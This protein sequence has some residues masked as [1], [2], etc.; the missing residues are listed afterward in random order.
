MSILPAHMFC[1][2]SFILDVQVRCQ[3]M[4]LNIIDMN[5]TVQVGQQEIRVYK[6]KLLNTIPYSSIIISYAIFGLY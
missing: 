1:D 2:V 5:V 6:N 4:Y 3:D